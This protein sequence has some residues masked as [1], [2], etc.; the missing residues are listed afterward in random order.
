MCIRD[1]NMPER[2]RRTAKAET[3]NPEVGN[4]PAPKA[5]SNLKAEDSQFKV[6]DAV[7]FLWAGLWWP[8]K[9]SSVRGNTRIE[10]FDNPPT[11]ELVEQSDMKQWS[12]RSRLCARRSSNEE[13]IRSLQRAEDYVA[14]QSKPKP[15]GSPVTVKRSADQ[16]GKGSKAASP[17][18]KRT[19]EQRSA[20]SKVG[21][22]VVSVKRAAEQ[23]NKGSKAASPITVKR[24]AEQPN[25]DTKAGSPVKRTAEPL[26]KGSKPA[27]SPLKRARK[28]NGNAGATPGHKKPTVAFTGAAPF[29]RAPSLTIETERVSPEPHHPTDTPVTL[30]ML[31]RFFKRN[32]EAQ[33]YNQVRTLTWSFGI[34]EIDKD[35]YRIKISRMVD[36]EL[37]EK[38]RHELQLDLSV[39]PVAAPSPMMLPEPS[40]KYPS[41]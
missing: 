22:P 13:Y 27:A 36:H 30:R 9:V 5:P 33:P 20:G 14:Q 15:L 25:K 18:T 28:L 2:V 38:S 1:S 39:P 32:L 19:A 23:Q 17:V 37:L 8:A 10:F 41:M 21:S 12:E 31:L 16:Q 11:Y 24:T 26:N 40:P 3:D 4:A 29:A 35:A 34:G 6:G 7:L